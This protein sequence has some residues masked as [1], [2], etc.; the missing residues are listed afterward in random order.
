MLACRSFRLIVE[1]VKINYRMLCMLSQSN[2]RN[3]LI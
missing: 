1:M 3:Q 2:R